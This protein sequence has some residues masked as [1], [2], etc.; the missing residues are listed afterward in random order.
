MKFN[1]WVGSWARWQT[2]NARTRAKRKGKEFTKTDYALYQTGNLIRQEG[3]AIS[4]KEYIRKIKP[5]LESNPPQVEELEAIMR[6]LLTLNRDFLEL[7]QLEKQDSR[8]VIT[9][10]TPEGIPIREDKRAIFERRFYSLEVRI[11]QYEDS[12]GVSFF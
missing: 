7:R 11:S 1:E 10:H 3:H 9:G 8:L 2:K 5:V 12:T 6:E 4:V